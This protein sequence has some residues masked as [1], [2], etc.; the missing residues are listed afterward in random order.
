[1]LANGTRVSK[2]KE[3]NHSTRNAAASEL[4]AWVW[5]AAHLVTAATTDL[6]RC[7]QG[8]PSKSAKSFES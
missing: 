3:T 4:T 8:G 5:Y 6:G 1:M 2:P 7:A